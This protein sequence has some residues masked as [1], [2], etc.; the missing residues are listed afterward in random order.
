V[1][2]ARARSRQKRSTSPCQLAES[3]ALS[4]ATAGPAQE[5]ISCT[6]AGFQAARPTPAMVDQLGKA[7]RLAR[8]LHKTVQAVPGQFSAG[9]PF[10]A[11][12]RHTRQVLDIKAAEV[13]WW[14]LE[15]LVYYNMCT[16][17]TMSNIAAIEEVMFR[18]NQNGRWMVSI[19]C[20]IY[21]A[22]LRISRIS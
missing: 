3:Y 6:L 21:F 16:D 11:W 7:E 13:R 12:L 8:R 2:S 15:V 18:Q 19:F 14:T 1:T 5:F 4:P 20:K 22:K 10:R 17:S 9:E